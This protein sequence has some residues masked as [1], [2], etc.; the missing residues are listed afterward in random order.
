MFCDSVSKGDMFLEVALY[1]K[2]EVI[3][4]ENKRHFPKREYEGTKI[5]S[6]AEFLEVLSPET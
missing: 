1:G 6:P 5:L 4:T 2:G 3:T